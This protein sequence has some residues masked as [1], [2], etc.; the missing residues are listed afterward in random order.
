MNNEKIYVGVGVIILVILGLLLFVRSKPRQAATDTTY[1]TVVFV[2]DGSKSVTATF[3]MTSDAQ[4]G[5]VL[6]DGRS[7]S[8]SHT[9]SADG[10]RYANSDESIVF[11]NKGNTAFITEGLGSKSPTTYANCVEQSIPNQ[12]A[13]TTMYTNDTY[14]F[15]IEYPKSLMATTTFTNNYILRNQWKSLASPNSTGVPIVSIP[16]L[17]INQGGVATG[18]SYPLSFDAEVHIGVSTNPADVVTCLEPDAGY[19]KEPEADV[20]IGGVSFTRFSFSDA[21][22]GTY[23]QGESYR[24]VHNDAC[25]AIEQIKTGSSYRDETMTPGYTDAQLN[26]YY[27]QAGDIIQSFQF[28]K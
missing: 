25:Y 28:T 7:M 10:A 14:G 3:D 11:W 4:V 9:V 8:L 24:A 22:M 26:D 21:A 27:N 12:N 19:T 5:L 23:L 16:V 1:K 13:T 18:R 17:R 20:T 6:S 15:Q 2:C